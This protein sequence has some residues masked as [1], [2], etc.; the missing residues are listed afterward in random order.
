MTT[1]SDAG[2]PPPPPGAPNPAPG[3]QGAPGQPPQ[4]GA[5]APAPSKAASVG[6]SILTRIVVA[7]VGLAVVAGV[8]YGWKVFKG[9]D[10]DLAKVGDCMA[11]TNADNLKVTKCTDAKATY[12]V[13]GKVEDKS[14]SAFNTDRSICAP[15]K[16]ADSAF[17][18]GEKGSN[19]YVLCLAPTK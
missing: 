17:W 18:K 15:F 16:D 2:S 14:E 1:P 7:V 5:P 12:K 10:P 11:G 6:K 4:Y 13:V 8:G 19:G 9:E 3:Q